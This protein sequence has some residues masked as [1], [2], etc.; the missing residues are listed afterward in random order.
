MTFTKGAERTCCIPREGR[1]SLQQPFLHA[2]VARA[3]TAEVSMSDKKRVVV[4]GPRPH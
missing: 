2:L 1:T 3:E 4:Q